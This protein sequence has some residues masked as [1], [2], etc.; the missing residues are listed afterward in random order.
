MLTQ[1]RGKVTWVSSLRSLIAPRAGGQ[2]NQMGFGEK[3]IIH[4]LC[5]SYI[6]A[7][8]LIVPFSFGGTVGK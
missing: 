8:F 7:Q 3:I 5:R 4:Y 6:M 2:P 1:Q